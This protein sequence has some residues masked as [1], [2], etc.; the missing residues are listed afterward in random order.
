MTA[1]RLLAIAQPCSDLDAQVAWYGEQLGFQVVARDHLEGPWIHRLFGCSAELRIARC[2]LSLGSEQLQLWQ[3]QAGS[4]AQSV[5]PLMQPVPADSRSNDRWF[6][7]ICMVTSNLNDCFSGLLQSH[8]TLIST[9]VQT[10]PEWN[11]GAAGIQAVKFTDPL[12][13]PLELLQFPADKGNPRWHTQS[14]LSSLPMG[15]DHT[16]IGI[17]DTPTSLRFYRDVLGMQLMGGS[18]NH[19]AEQDGLDGL[20]HTMV[21]ISS[22]RPQVGEMGIEFLNYQQPAGGRNRL[23]AQVTDL[24]DWKILLES[25]DLERQY[26]ALKASE[27]ADSCGALVDLDPSFCAKRRGFF[28]RDPDQHAIVVL[29][30]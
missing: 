19:G 6:Q 12:G 11:Q 23:D 1:Q 5:T 24:C 26:A 22:L 17:S 10:L 18:V 16:A 29:G 3:W 14:S 20:E 27:W 28:V 13:H 21:D 8:A 7:H 15:I 25:S 4:T 30:D 9:A 2:V